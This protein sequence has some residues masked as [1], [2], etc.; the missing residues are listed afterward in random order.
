MAGDRTISS[1]YNRLN[2]NPALFSQVLIM[3]RFL[4]G[5]L[6][7]NFM[8]VFVAYWYNSVT[9]ELA[10]IKGV[11]LGTFVF[12]LCVYLDYKYKLVDKVLE[13]M[14]ED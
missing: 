3:L 2:F 4:E 8:G 5:L 14:S 10:V 11:G 7:G 1:P 12:L 9:P 13:S 6:L